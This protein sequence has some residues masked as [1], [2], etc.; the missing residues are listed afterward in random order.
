MS[1]TLWRLATQSVTSRPLGVFRAAIGL[2]AVLKGAQLAPDLAVANWLESASLEFH[3]TL[4]PVLATF[5]FTAALALLVGYRSRL[6]ALAIAVL[7]ALITLLTGHFYNNLYFLGTLALLLS[8]TE[9]GSYFS[10]DSL[11]RGVRNEV[12]RLPVLL[13]QLQVSVVYLYSAV[14]K[15]NLEFIPGNVIFYQAERAW[16]APELGY[17]PLLTA[18]A[19]IVIVL[20]LFIAVGLWID[21]LR[22]AAFGI[23]LGLHTGMLLLLSD[24]LVLAAA[25]TLFALF[26][27]SCYLLFVK[28][29]LGGRM[30]IWDDQCSLCATWIRRIK[31]LDWLGAFTFVGAGDVAAYRHTGVTPA[32]SQ[33]ALQ[34]V[35]LGGKI[36]SGF[37]AVRR[38]L[39]AFPLTFLWAPYLGLWPIRAIG[40]RAYR[41][42]ADRRTHGSVCAHEPTAAGG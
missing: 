13:I 36:Y 22:P 2:A 3:I 11:R 37:E 24:S 41:M 38:I 15:I 20:E 30:V 40:D 5:W 32:S 8:L 19:V 23:G 29:P 34:L 27:L 16:A 35:D 6:A 28:A 1:W 31:R 4:W 17:A 9:C 39:Q 26:T 12:P 14:G 18:M 25:L 33:E 10:L 21:R 42:V 7:T